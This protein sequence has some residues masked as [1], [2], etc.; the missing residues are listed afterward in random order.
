MNTKN[1]LSSAEYIFT[2]NHKKHVCKITRIDEEVTHIECLSAWINQDFPNEDVA[3]MLLEIPAIILEN[4]KIDR[5][6]STIIQIRISSVEKV[7]LKEKALKS[8][9][10]NVS[11]Y[12]R[13]TIL[14]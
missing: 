2:L 4:E 7:R 11:S 5:E 8:G 1:L 9:F 13:S 10:N 3:D 6:K 12:V 14:K